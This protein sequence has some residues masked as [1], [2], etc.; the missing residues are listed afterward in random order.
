MIIELKTTKNQVILVNTDNVTHIEPHTT[1]GNTEIY[2]IGGKTVA[3]HGTVESHKSAFRV[4]A[5]PAGSLN[6]SV[7]AKT[8]RVVD[9]E[10][11]TDEAPE[12]TFGVGA[13]VVVEAKKASTPEPKKPA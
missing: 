4:V 5:E 7:K 10:I 13:K 2:F 11:V 12:P 6:T 3:V 1:E 8:P 9:E